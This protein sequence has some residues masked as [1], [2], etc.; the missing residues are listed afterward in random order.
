M[1]NLMS[2]TTSTKEAISI[3]KELSE[4]LDVSGL[5]LRKRSSNTP[6]MLTYLVENPEVKKSNLE[7]N[8]ENC[9]KT[10][11]LM[12]DSSSDCFSF[13]LVDFIQF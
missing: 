6:E 11:G 8:P 9:R 5:H 4:V 13:M 3:I 7:I 10:V 12:W 1:D 2:G